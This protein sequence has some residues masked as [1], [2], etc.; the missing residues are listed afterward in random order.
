MKTLIACA[1]KS[2]TTRAC[3]E[4]LARKI[5]EATLVDLTREKPNPSGYD[6][7]IVGGNVRM[8]ALSVDT[9][10][11]L[12]GAK[13]ALLAKRLGI[14]ICAGFDEKKDAIFENNVDPELLRHAVRYDSFGG[15]IRLD[16]LH[17]FEKLI[18]RMV[19][20]PGK[21]DPAELPRLFP[22]RIEA[23]AQAFAPEESGK[24]EEG[25]TCST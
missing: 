6:Q 2:G 15:E 18:T 20:K 9:R 17:G 8:G 12:D 13:P 3:A 10:Q 4:A 1:S 22:E 19:M 25:Q 16:R 24:G 14:F 7:I 11:Y 21:S 23:F 5:P